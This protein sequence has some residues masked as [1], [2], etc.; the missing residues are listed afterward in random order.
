MPLEVRNE[1]EK[2]GVVV[3]L[4]WIHEGGANREYVIDQLEKLMNL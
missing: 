3:F 4:D 1:Y 2:N